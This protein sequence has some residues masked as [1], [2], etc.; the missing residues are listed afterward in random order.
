MSQIPYEALA[1][2]RHSAIIA[3][4]ILR[5][6]LRALTTVPIKALQFVQPGRLARVVRK[7]GSSDNGGG[8]GGGVEGEVDWG[9]GVLLNFKRR[10]DRPRLDSG[11]KSKG[12]EG[13]P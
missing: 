1:S 5:A 4:R 2:E 11:K 12:G 13:P 9:W 3:E 10:A 7:G 6:E 8:G